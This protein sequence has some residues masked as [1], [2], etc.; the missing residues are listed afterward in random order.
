L[1]ERE[2][3]RFGNYVDYEYTELP[4][5]D[6]HP[7]FE[8]VPYRVWSTGHTAGEAPRRASG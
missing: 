2:V 7:G 5:S 3:D 1:L 4:V 6:N 8:V